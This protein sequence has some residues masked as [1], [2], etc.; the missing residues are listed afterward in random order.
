MNIFE[1]FYAVIR[2]IPRG[3]VA[4]YGQIA[5]LTG[6]TGHARQVGYALAAIKEDA[7]PWHRVTN[8]KGEISM[9]AVPHFAMIQRVRLMKEGIAIDKNGRISL[10]RFQWKNR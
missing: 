3:R 10:E 4:T 7:I 1:R 2:H 9:R 6:L 8:S 5:Q